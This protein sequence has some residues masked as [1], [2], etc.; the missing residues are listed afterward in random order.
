MTR[1]P[2]SCPREGVGIAYSSY[3]AFGGAQSAPFSSQ[4]LASRHPLGSPGEGWSSEPISPPQ[5]GEAFP[6][7]SLPMINNNYRFFSTG[8]SEGWLATFTEPVLGVGGQA[9][10][11][12]LYRRALTGSEDY[13]ACTTAT[14]QGD[15]RA[16]QAELQGVSEGGARAVFRADDKLTED[17]EE[18]SEAG[19]ATNFQ[20][21]ACDREAAGARAALTWSA[22][23]PTG[24]EHRRIQHRGGGQLGRSRGRRAGW[25]R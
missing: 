5:E 9:G 4:Y 10:F 2:R 22:C 12:N 11:A 23:C 6:H 19:K 1:A 7:T 16:Y 3:R 21:Y 13:E 24:R 18:P 17:A 20:L 25:R 14:P 15:T 8:L